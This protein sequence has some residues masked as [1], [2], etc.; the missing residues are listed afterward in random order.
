MPN[1]NFPA[2]ASVNQIY[3]FNNNTW[4]Y[5]GYAWVLSGGSNGTHAS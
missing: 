2:T 1:I 4:I 5:N 3:I